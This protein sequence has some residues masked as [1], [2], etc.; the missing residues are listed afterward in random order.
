MAL[1]RA[2]RGRQTLVPR[3]FLYVHCPRLAA[4]GRKKAEK[5]PA[6]KQAVAKK[7]AKK[8]VSG[9][10]KKSNR[11]CQVVDSGKKCGKPAAVHATPSPAP[12]HA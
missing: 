2:A 1:P 7:I 3:T 10:K 8:P 11:S 4:M 9:N 12:Q 6:E 5:K